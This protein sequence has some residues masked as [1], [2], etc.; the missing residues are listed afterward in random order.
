MRIY[1]NSLHTEQLQKWIRERWGLGRLYR[2]MKHLY[3]SHGETIL[4]RQIIRE[5]RM[6]GVRFPM[7]IIDRVMQEEKFSRT[8][9]KAIRDWVTGE[10]D[11]LIY[12][13]IQR[14]ISRV[15][16]ENE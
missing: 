2:Q 6:I 15:E 13:A 7:V 5:A 4:L 14:K 9:K 10:E 16:A 1:D 12:I 8:E 11:G 3:P